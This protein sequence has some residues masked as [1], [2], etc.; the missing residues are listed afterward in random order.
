MQ[1]QYKGKYIEYMERSN[2]WTIHEFDGEEFAS[3]VEARKYIDQ[4][5][6][7]K[8]KRFTALVGNRL[9]DITSNATH[10]RC[11]FTPQIKE[12]ACRGY[13]DHRQMV[14]RNTVY[15]V[16]ENQEAIAKWRELDVAIEKAQAHVQEL[17][18]QRGHIVNSEMKSYPT[19]HPEVA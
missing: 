16:V 19:L 11:W 17:K 8:F 5:A 18:D 13:G 6:K 1:E 4:Q 2:I 14:D 9:G 3:L 7:E 15:P 10:G 12:G